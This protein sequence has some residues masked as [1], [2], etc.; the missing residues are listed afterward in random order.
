MLFT[1]MMGVTF[2]WKWTDISHTVMQKRYVYIKYQPL[3]GYSAQLSLGLLMRHTHKHTQNHAWTGRW[4][5]WIAHESQ[6]MK[7]DNMDKQRTADIYGCW[8]SSAGFWFSTAIGLASSSPKLY[9][10]STYRNMSSAAQHIFHRKMSAKFPT[11]P[12]I[13]NLISSP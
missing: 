4:F 7:P 12:N 3:Y 1:M 5:L 10:P 2:E 9:A 6:Y 8:P 11:T 13:S